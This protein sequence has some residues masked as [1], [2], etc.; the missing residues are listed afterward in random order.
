MLNYLEIMNKFIAFSITILLASTQLV[1][2]Q[3][4]WVWQG[5][6]AGWTGAGGCSLAAEAD[7]L[8]MTVTGNQPHMQSPT[9]LN[10][11]GDNYD[12]FDITVQNHTNVSPFVLKWFDASNSF[13][14]QATIPVSTQMTTPETYT[15]SLTDNATW[16]GNTIGKFRLRG[17]AGGGEALGEVDW[18]SFSMNLTSEAV[19]GCMDPL[20]CNYDS[21]ATEESGDCLFNGAA[22]PT[23]FYWQGTKAGWTGAGGLI[24]TE[25]PEHMTMTVTGTNNVAE[26]QSPTG[27]ALSAAQFGSFTVRLL[28]PTTVSG[29]FQLRWYDENNTLLGNTSIPVNTE[30]SAMETYTVNLSNEESWVG[31]IHKLRLRGPFALDVETESSDILWEYFE[32]NEVFDC[33]GNCAADLDNDGI[34]DA[35]DA[36][37]ISG[38]TSST[39][40][41]FNAEACQDDG[42]CN[43]VGANSPINYEWQGTKAGWIGAGGVSLSQGPDFMTM[44]VT[45]ASSVA[46]MQSPTNLGVDAASF[47]TFSVTVQNPSSV[48]GGFQLRWYD[49]TGAILGSQLIPIDTGMDEP[50]TYQVD[51][52]GNPNWNGTIDKFRLRGPFELDVSQEPNEVYWVDFSLNAA[53]DC[54]GNC[55]ATVDDCGICGGDGSS[56]LQPGC[57]DPFYFEFNFDATSDD[58]S[59]ETLVVHGCTYEIATNFNSA[60]NSEDGS[61]IIPTESNCA[62]DLDDDGLVA[63]PDLLMFLSAFGFSCE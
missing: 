8:T 22:I 28:N 53:I 60:A 1:V 38:C 13:V 6:T 50:S 21:S 12:S 58:G 52:T 20:A 14:G 49:E 46:E 61:C 16:A 30:M 24:L 2:G 56:C 51:L 43:F 34:C 25:G 48:S 9:G 41:N 63:I 36:C 19:S 35:L 45:G 5:T 31:A 3:D 7:F 10:L 59:C 47:S 39:A 29:G 27:L 26:M 18:F 33:D 4:A 11:V 17:P 62:A 37:V 55:I 15:V 57:T 32:M 23:D 42:T 44:T 40:C 54:D